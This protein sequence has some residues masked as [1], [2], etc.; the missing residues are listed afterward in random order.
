MEQAHPV[1]GIDNKYGQCVDDIDIDTS[2]L[3]DYLTGRGLNDEQ[4]NE[5]IVHFSS[6]RVERLGKTILGRCYPRTGLIQLYVLDGLQQLRTT[7][8]IAECDAYAQRKIGQVL[9]HELEH[10]IIHTQPLPGELQAHYDR[11]AQLYD[12]AFT[13]DEKRAAEKWAYNNSPEETLCNAA[14]ADAPAGLVIIKM[15]PVQSAHPAGK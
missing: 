3:H 4:I 15:K 9:T 6:E 2:V 8:S 13:D 7:D 12:E 10:R 1:I 5:T 14:E 11:A